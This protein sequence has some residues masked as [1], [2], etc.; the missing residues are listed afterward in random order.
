MFKK[1]P[2][3][4]FKFKVKKIIPLL[5]KTGETI[6]LIFF[7]LFNFK[8]GRNCYFVVKVIQGLKAGVEI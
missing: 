1:F 2:I 7:N 8:T 3:F 4:F 6:L 5:K